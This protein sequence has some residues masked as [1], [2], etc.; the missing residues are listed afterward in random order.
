[1]LALDD[2]WAF[3]PCG[4]SQFCNNCSET[5]INNTYINTRNQNRDV[6]GLVCRKKVKSRLVTA[7]NLLY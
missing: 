3:V 6:P 5:V 4:H 7:N 1:M 2:V